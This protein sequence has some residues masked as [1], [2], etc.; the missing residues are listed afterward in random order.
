MA[1]TG[2]SHPHSP[3]RPDNMVGLFRPI[4]GSRGAFSLTVF[5]R[6][7][8]IAG[9]Q[10]FARVAQQPLKAILGFQGG[11]TGRLER[12]PSEGDRLYLRYSG[13]IEFSTPIVYHSAEAPRVA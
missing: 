12:P 7:V 8:P 11:F 10:L 5:T 3:E 4:E 9:R 6:R 13:S 2:T 1:A